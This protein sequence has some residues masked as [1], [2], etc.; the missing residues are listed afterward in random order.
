MSR[1]GES[2]TNKLLEGNSIWQDTLFLLL[3]SDSV[4][5]RESEAVLHYQECGQGDIPSCKLI[6]NGSSLN[7]T[8]FLK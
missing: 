2:E 1:L 6:E 3:P 5:Y 8:E 7:N 4:D